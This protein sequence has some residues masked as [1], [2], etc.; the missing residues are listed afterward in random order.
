MSDV[1]AERAAV[2]A[3]LKAV[4]REG[5]KAA[6]VYATVDGTC[7]LVVVEL[8]STLAGIELPALGPVPGRAAAALLAGLLV[9]AAEFAVRVR[10]PLVDRFA[11][12]NPEVATALRTTRDAVDRDRD[13]PMA[14]RLYADTR[15]QLT[16][17]SSRGLLDMRRIAATI[18]VVCALGATTVGVGAAGPTLLGPAE[19]AATPGGGPSGGIDSTPTPEAYDGLRNGDEVLGT[20]GE[21]DRGEQSQTARVGTNPD[22]SGDRTPPPNEFDAAGTAGTSE[23][24]A[25]RAGF[26]G[27]PTLEDAT[28]VREYY[29]RIRNDTDSQ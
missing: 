15:E 13:D 14:R 29:L 12:V 7:T 1:S 10:R 25:Q 6:A 11:A 16:Q 20:P 24:D 2:E 27:E 22:A 23:Y 3:A 21:V 5:W 28:L 17:A 4:R 18:L 8:A 9:G 19:P 26:A